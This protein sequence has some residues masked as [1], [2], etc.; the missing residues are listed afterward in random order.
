MHLWLLSSFPSTRSHLP[1]STVLYLQLGSSAGWREWKDIFLPFTGCSSILAWCLTSSA[2][3]Q[4]FDS[5][6]EKHPGLQHDNCCFQLHAICTYN[7]CTVLHTPGLSWK[8]KIFWA[9]NRALTIQCALCPNKS[10]FITPQ[11]YIFTC[12]CTTLLFLLQLWTNNC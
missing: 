5:Y 8:Q 12:F 2:T 6:S 9:P 3:M 4:H 10:F 7:K 11:G 1:H